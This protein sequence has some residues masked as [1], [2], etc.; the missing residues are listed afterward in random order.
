MRFFFIFFLFFFNFYINAAEVIILHKSPSDLVQ[1][2]EEDLKNEKFDFDKA[3]LKLNNL[4]LDYKL[5]KVCDSRS[6]LRDKDFPDSSYQNIRLKLDIFCLVLQ[7]KFDE[8]NLL[9]SAVLM[10]TK[11]KDGDEFFQDLF[12]GLVYGRGESIGLMH[13]KYNREL[14]PLY[15]AMMRL[16]H[17]G[18]TV[19]WSTEFLKYDQLLIPIMLDWRA[20]KNIRIKAARYAYRSGILSK[21]KS[22]NCIEAIEE[23]IK[24]FTPE[25]SCFKDPFEDQ[26]EDKVQIDNYTQT[27][28]PF[29]KPK[30]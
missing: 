8:A 1:T 18:I 6:L 16:L 27:I 15:S 13:A 23:R 21:K 10:E 29:D 11:S 24:L 30:F 14:L 2:T 3:V 17:E 28:K 5:S 20:D 7:E 9:N 22:D 12:K 4:L 26:T 19:I 25:G